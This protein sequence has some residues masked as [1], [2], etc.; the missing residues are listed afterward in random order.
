MTATELLRQQI[1]TAQIPPG[2]LLNQS[3]LAK[4]LGTSRVPVR[5][6]LIRL[7]AQHLIELRDGVARVARLS[8]PDLEE[9]YELREAIEPA[10]TRI[11]LPN[12]GR[13]EILQMEK[14]LELMGDT[15]ELGGWLTANRQFHRL[16]YGQSNRVQTIGLI[17]SL[18]ERTDRYLF[19]YVPA[20][21]DGL[22]RFDEQHQLILDAARAGA[23]GEIEELT[24]LHLVT[25]H[26]MILGR[27]LDGTMQTGSH[28]LSPRHRSEPLVQSNSDRRS[29]Q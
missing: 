12:V 23:G 10:A 25:A 15:D 6:A 9:I 28:E 7:A 18:A 4:T 27:M 2:T 24:K 26:R 13:A 14:L 19:H 22:Q 5:D 8:M 1:I 11:A 29:R 21:D 20:L 16:V 17:D 3:A